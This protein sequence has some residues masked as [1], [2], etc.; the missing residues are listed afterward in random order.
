MK[1]DKIVSAYEEIK[2]DAYAKQRVWSKVTEPKR[3]RRTIPML[4]AVA[5]V[6]AI[7]VFAHSLFPAQISNSFMVRAYAMGQQADGRMDW[8]SFDLSANQDGMWS[9]FFDGT[10]LYLHIRLEVTGENI[11]G[12]E[13]GVD[14]GFFARIVYEDKIVCLLT[15]V[16]YWP[17]TEFEPLGNRISLADMQGDDVLFFLA[18]PYF[19]GDSMIWYRAFDGANPLELQVD[20]TFRD[21]EEQSGVVPLHFGDGGGTM[22]YHPDLGTIGNLGFS[23]INLENATLIPESMQVLP[24]YEDI[25][26]QFGVDMYIWERERGDILASRLLFRA[27]GDEL[28]YHLSNV[29]GDVILSLI[30]VNEA[31]QLVG[32]EYILPADEARFFREYWES[33][34]YVLPDEVAEGFRELWRSSAYL[35][36]DELAERFRAL[37]E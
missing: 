20:V 7:V 1:H 3:K 33:T 10:Y 37:W 15:G 12:V 19:F 5:A 17:G 11:A 24:L 9:G 8:L 2:P 4:A 21:G 22:D 32:M 27:P 31:G 26:G 14:E 23:H 25:S 30:R 29:D 13:F 18:I 6:L 35:S 34:P 28:R 36:P 16:Y